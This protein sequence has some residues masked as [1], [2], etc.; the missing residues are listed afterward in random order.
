VCYIAALNEL[1]LF[2][3]VLLIIIIYYKMK[4]F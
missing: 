4:V 2:I 1:V 3:V